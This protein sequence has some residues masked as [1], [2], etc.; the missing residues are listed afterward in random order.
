M[1]EI[2]DL[3]KKNHFND[4]TYHYNDNTAPKTFIGFKG[5]LNFNSL[6]EDYITLEKLE[7]KQNE[8]KSELIKIVKGSKKSDD[9]KCKKNIKTLYDSRE[10]VSKLIDDY[11][12]IV[13]EAKFKIKYGEGLKILTPIQM[14]QRLS[15][16][17]AQVKEDNTFEN[18]LNEIRQVVYLLY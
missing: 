4:L 5:P 14:L 16:A 6:K 12:R 15:I 18:L 11:F 17:L 1:E 9:Q 3:S 7:E 2:E 8:L 10:R 13:S